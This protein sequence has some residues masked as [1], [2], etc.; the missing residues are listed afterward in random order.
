MAR[1][2][3]SLWYK[4]A[5]IYEL[6]VKAFRDSNG[7]GCGDFRGLIEKLDYLEAL[8]VTAIWLLPF[9]PSPRRDDG[10][11]I[12]DYRGIHPDYGT[13]RDFKAFVREAHKRGM[14]VITELV[15]NHT[16]DQHP[17]FQAARRAKPGSAMRD[18]YVWS[19]TDEKFPE[20]RIIF[21]DTESSNWTW[22]PVAGQYYWHR[23]FSH[24]PD[25]NHNNPRV[26]QAVIRTLRFWLKTGVDGLRLDAIPYLCVREGTTNENLP[27][28][29][30]VIKQ[31]RAAVDAE[32][33]D[34]LLLAE[35]NQW[36]EDVVE[37][38][39]EGDECHLAYHFPVMPRI[40]MALR[41]EDR[42]PI[43]EILRRTP[44]IPDTCQWAL[45]LRNHDELTLEMVTDEERDY[46][47]REYAA[48][49]RM[50]LNAGIRR[51]L[52]PLLN[53]DRQS[54]ELLNSLLFS[55]PGTPIL[56]YGDELGMGDNIYLGDRDG[57]RTPMQ[58]SLDRNAGFS[59]ADPARLYLPVIM[60]PVYGY[61]ALN[62]EA[63]ERSRSSMLHF[64]RRLVSLRRQH[65]AF[66]RGTME[67]LDADNRKVLAYL[68]RYQG[69][70]IL[71]VANLSRFT[72]PVQL[73]LREFDG[74]TPVEMIGRT[75][76][77]TIGELPYFLTL[78]AHA[79]YWFRL[80]P[81]PEPIHAGGP[82]QAAIQQTDHETLPLLAIARPGDL[83]E[84]DSRYVLEQEVLPDYLV[85]QRWYRGKARELISVRLVDWS[86]LG[87][88]FFLALAE[89][90]YE[91][92]G[93]ER[94]AL[95]LKAITGKAAGRVAAEL[96]GSVMARLR[97]AT[98]AGVLCDALVDRTSG[99]G[100]YAAMADG[101][102]FATEH[103]GV[104]R[105]FP[106]RG[107][108]GAAPPR[109]AARRLRHL[110]VEQSN[111]SIVLDDTAIMKLF[112]VVETGPNPD[113]EIGLHLTERTSF[114]RMPRV[115]GGVIYRDPD[116]AESTLAMLQEFVPNEGDGWKHGLIAVRAA[117][118]NLAAAGWPAPPPP[119][120][121]PP[122]ALDPASM[123]APLREA[124]G[125]FPQLARRL[126]AD[127][128]ACHRALAQE[129]R[130]ADF[131]PRPLTGVEL[132]TVADGAVRRAQHILEVLN[133]GVGALP[134]ELHELA[135]RVLGAGPQLLA[136]FQHLTR[137]REAGQRIRVHGDYHLGQV[138]LTGE[139]W[140]LLDFEGEPMRPLADRRQKQ[141]PLKDVAGML[142]SFDYAAQAVRL[143]AP[144]DLA[145][146]VAAAR[147]GWCGAWSQ[148]L[149]AAFVAGYLEGVEGADLLPPDAEARDTL[150]D[151]FLLDKAFYELEYELSNRP[152][153]VGVPLAG[154][155]AIAARRPAEP[156]PENV[157]V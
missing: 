125:T 143:E 75:E 46:M 144:A 15:V 116:G 47:Y 83:L 57:V 34:R 29:H 124:A 26:V 3:H 114:T 18:F 10:Y 14:R 20:T 6:H 86:K 40:F 37:Y 126:G 71:C 110:G 60:D 35:A 79:F 149:G 76:F 96:P 43:T 30:A 148:W 32:F 145:P 132:E 63:Q 157:S 59:T 100:L 112:R 25:L 58:W 51:R 97:T 62:V 81:Q 13:L 94:Y 107:A 127:T 92:G 122:A 21:S 84:P 102:E 23:F 121:A 7:D 152:D 67:F 39:G 137:L 113:L 154:I 42:R 12:S 53:N 105:A 98:G 138:L 19:D 153:W 22:D 139:D 141:S 129:K 44:P 87:G 133:A 151:A 2:P 49:P 55:F 118:E 88:G 90:G 101:R 9:Y 69:E 65:K 106:V 155:A 147:A 119:V 99:A 5:I 128:A 28:T 1:R 131:T 103:G 54:I 111:T 134:E 61:Q 74:W 142:R 82:S 31:I 56:Y 78:G 64:M 93:H 45:F 85:R 117:L 48:D 66:G 73:D 150:L 17:W 8:G 36:P 52:A 80:E 72:Q 104:I 135:D 120:L 41:Q 77:P 91:D 123:P 89:A 24:Q 140:L 33:D 115:Q 68:R 108:D 95:T 50:R 146:E 136:R 156:G 16:S 109:L 11:D 70:T 27:E 38:F 130:R 4:D